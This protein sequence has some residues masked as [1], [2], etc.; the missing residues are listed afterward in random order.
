MGLLL[1]HAT[2][3]ASAAWRAN[4]WSGRVFSDREPDKEAIATLGS[5]SCSSTHTE[6]NGRSGRCVDSR[7][8]WLGRPQRSFWLPKPDRPFGDDKEC[9]PPKAGE[10]KGCYCR[11]PYPRQRFSWQNRHFI[12]AQ[13]T[14]RQ[15][16]TKSCDVLHSAI[17]CRCFGLYHLICIGG[18][19][20]TE[21]CR[22]GMCLDHSI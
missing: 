16:I 14:P 17:W 6:P 15:A 10:H 1:V 19:I 21:F 22:W 9:T 5:E 4:F 2:F 18:G 7:A 8:P 3:E 20:S 11:W 12:Y 13:L